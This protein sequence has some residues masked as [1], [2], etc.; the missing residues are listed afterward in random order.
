M[1][2]GRSRARAETVG[3]QREDWTLPDL[4][5]LSDRAREQF[6]DMLGE[7]DGPKDIVIQSEL[8]SLLE[9][10]TPMKF[11]R[12]YSCMDYSTFNKTCSVAVQS[13]KR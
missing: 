5:L 6:A 11:L 10:V 1:A 2:E 4:Q 12:R 9:H 3:A 13:E 7:V 8:M